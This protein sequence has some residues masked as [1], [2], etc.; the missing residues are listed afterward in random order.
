MLGLPLRGGGVINLNKYL[1]N[2]YFKCFSISSN[3]NK[4]NN[5]N[6]NSK[7]NNLNLELVTTNINKYP[8]LL[9]LN[10]DPSSKA[11]TKYNEIKGSNI[12]LKAGE[13]KRFRIYKDLELNLS[14]FIDNL[15]ESVVYSIGFNVFNRI[16]GY[17]SLGEHLLVT[18]EIN[19]ESLLIH[20]ESLLIRRILSYN[21]DVDIDENLLENL[22]FIEITYKSV[23]ILVR[24]Y[25]I[26]SKEDV[27][28]KR[29]NEI[30]GVENKIIIDNSERKITEETQKNNKLM[31]KNN[32]KYL[33]IIPLFSNLNKLGLLL[34]DKYV[35]NGI[36]GRFYKFSHDIKLFIYEI[37]SSSYKVI[38]FKKDVEYFRFVDFNQDH[39]K[40]S[41]I[42]LID[43]LFLYYENGSLIYS[44]KI[45]KTKALNKE[46][47]E[48]VRDEKY[49]A[50]DIETY[51]ENNKFVPFACAYYKGSDKGDKHIKLKIYSV[52]NYKNWEDMMDK[53]LIELFNEF[54]NHTIYAHNLGGFDSLYLIQSLC[55]ISNVKPLFKD[56]KLIS[57]VAKYTKKDKSGR[58]KNI[59]LKFHD[60]LALFPFSLDRLIKSLGID[61]PK[62]AFPYYFPNKDNLNYIGNFPVYEYFDSNKLN[63]SEYEKLCSQYKNKL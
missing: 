17:K 62:L 21:E 41:F 36:T 53:V 7:S 3:I 27:L 58:T 2:N 9:D 38:V 37:T 18:K 33:N 4:N 29:L 48:I 24:D 57:I 63:K 14:K 11:I 60:S 26:I 31:I 55:R 23:S 5:N 32:L 13:I 61:T 49:V 46:K 6:N 15:N 45:I 47:R 12:S 35:F 43:K 30:S 52:L 16:N 10:I 25:N 19:K 20:L 51:L 56:N 50:F 39:L 8:E 40:N 1:Y 59:K 44:D 22:S 54:P 28:N 34:N 42:R